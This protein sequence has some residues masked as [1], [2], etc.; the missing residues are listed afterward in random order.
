MNLKFSK[1]KII[2]KKSLT[3]LDKLV[4]R[5][6]KI[7]EKLKINYVIISG[8]VVILFGRSRNTEDIDLFV[9]EMPFKKF[10]SFWTELEKAGFECINAFTV[11]EAYTDFLQQ[12]LAIRFAEKGFFEPNFEIKFPQNKWN[13]YS[14]FHIVKV[15]L[16]EEEKLNT[17]E[18]ELQI[19]FKLFLGSEKDFEDARHLYKFFQENLNMSLLKNHIKELNVEKEAKAVLWKN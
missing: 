2:F 7:L 11:E 14:L 9:E 18:I 16:E 6:V 15:F 3:D 5:F 12:K 17:S 13:Y 4:L 1:N 19:A 8:Y 10:A